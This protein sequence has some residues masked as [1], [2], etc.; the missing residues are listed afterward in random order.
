MVVVLLQYGYGTTVCHNVM[1][2]NKEA[3]TVGGMNHLASPVA[4][5]C[6]LVHYY[7]INLRYNFQL[8][9]IKNGI[10]F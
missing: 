10:Y 5:C 3:K 1:L 8:S 4:V 2:D 7:K 6:S 9:R